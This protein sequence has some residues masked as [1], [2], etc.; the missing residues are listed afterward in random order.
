MVLTNKQHTISDINDN[1]LKL[2]DL[3]K[4]NVGATGQKNG[5][6]FDSSVKQTDMTFGLIGIKERTSMLQ[7]TCV[8]FS[9]PGKGT[10][11]KVTI[12]LS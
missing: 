9:K 8:I 12:P 6:G 3:N 4:E 10:V 2:I 11:I 1:V 5:I 7:E